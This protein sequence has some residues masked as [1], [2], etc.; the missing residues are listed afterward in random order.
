M[1]WTRERVAH[2]LIGREQRLIDEA[3]CRKA[4]L[5]KQLWH[6]QGFMQHLRVL[7]ATRAR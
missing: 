4:K 5:C 6:S 1:V 7:L 2:D 3:L